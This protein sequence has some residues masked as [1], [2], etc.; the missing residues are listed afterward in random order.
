MKNLF[1]SMCMVALSTMGFGQEVVKRSELYQDPTDNLLSQFVIDVEGKTSSE[2]KSSVELWASSIF[3]NTDA[4]TVANGENY[5]V[6]KPLTTISYNAGMGAI[7]EG[8]MYMHTKFEFKDSKIRVTIVEHE[9][10]YTSQYGTTSRITWPSKMGSREI[11]D[12]I[13]NKGM[14]KATY[15]YYVKAISKKDEWVNNIKNINF[16]SSYTS[17]W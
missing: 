6:Y 11:P 7:A 1:L 13:K 8:K 5:V 9:S 4:V 14:W 17:D 10:V 3:N 16:T 15:R 12:E 2:L